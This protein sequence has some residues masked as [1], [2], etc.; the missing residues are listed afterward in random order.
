MHRNSSTMIDDVLEELT[1]KED[2]LKENSLGV[3]VKAKL[4]DIASAKSFIEGNRGNITKVRLYSDAEIMKKGGKELLTLVLYSVR[5]FYG[6]IYRALALPLLGDIMI[7]AFM[8]NHNV[9]IDTYNQLLIQDPSTRDFVSELNK[10]LGN[11][12]EVEAQ[13]AEEGYKKIIPFKTKVPNKSAT[14]LRLANP[15]DWIKYNTRK[16]EV[17]SNN[18]DETLWSVAEREARVYGM[19]N[20]PYG[21][22]GYLSNCIMYFLNNS[23]LLNYGSDAT[24]SEKVIKDIAW[25]GA[26][27]GEALYIAFQKVGVNT[28]N[29]GMQF[30]P[31]LYYMRLMGAEGLR[32][33]NDLHGIDNSKWK[34]V[35][36]SYKN[37]HW[38]ITPNKE[39]GFDVTHKN[40]FSNKTTFIGNYA[41]VANAQSEISGTYGKLPE[42]LINAL[43]P[44]KRQ[45]FVFD[46]KPKSPG[47]IE[48]QYDLNTRERFN[49]QMR[50]LV[51][52]ITVPL[53]LSLMYDIDYD[54]ETG[55]PILVRNDEFK[56]RV[57][58]NMVNSFEKSKLV[59]KGL[60]P[61]S[62]Q[63]KTGKVWRTPLDLRGT[64]LEPMFY[65]LYAADDMQYSNF[66]EA[67]GVLSPNN[68]FGY[69]TTIAKLVHASL[70]LAGNDV[71]FKDFSD[72]YSSL[73]SLGF[74]YSNP[75]DQRQAAS[76]Y[77][78]REKLI[79]KL[80]EPFVRWAY[81]G[82]MW[83]SINMISGKDE[84]R[85]RSVAPGLQ[86]WADSFH[87][88]T[89]FG[90]IG[91]LKD[92]SI[93]AHT[94]KWLTS[95]WMQSTGIPQFMFGLN[96]KF[97][98]NFIPFVSSTGIPEK[99][100][101]N[102]YGNWSF[103]APKRNLEEENGYDTWITSHKDVFEGYTYPPLNTFINGLTVNEENR[104]LRAN[105]LKLESDLVKLYFDNNKGIAAKIEEIPS[106][107]S[108]PGYFKDNEPIKT[109]HRI[110]FNNNLRDKAYQAAIVL[111]IMK[112][113]AENKDNNSADALGTNLGTMPENK[114]PYGGDG[115]LELKYV[116]SDK[117]SFNSGDDKWVKAEPKPDTEPF[118]SMDEPLNLEVNTSKLSVDLSSIGYEQGVTINTNISTDKLKDIFRVTTINVPIKG[119]DGIIRY[120]KRTG[121]A[122]NAQN[123]LVHY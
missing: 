11:T 33:I 42:W 4:K 60:Q 83:R 88:G 106:S 73:A 30:F 117:S 112:L 79:K 86:Q 38:T 87:G 71:F 8:T 62:V 44:N 111:S 31:F 95:D 28:F 25:I 67:G 120:E 78:A 24:N 65:G 69:Y 89:V 40:T 22:T 91:D 96:G 107:F 74:A 27:I 15:A 109:K 100:Y 63:I 110:R 7:R 2:F 1:E 98:D 36:D 122:L 68:E 123:L 34:K 116:L 19:M 94:A 75:L 56:L 35:G 41:T 64:P 121:V 99:V 66:T 20:K 26:K 51:G 29:L 21:Y 118:G 90:A 84:I 50:A 108:A 81:G 97:E 119:K 10:A 39:S 17:I 16:Q 102:V 54:K 113:M 92:A 72:T 57:N 103:L 9:V 45:T 3:G 23:S 49:V 18:T 80:R 32:K 5:L 46:P 61:R 114:N 76:S 59:E 53:L 55:R 104:Q 85:Y 14:G 105:I 115:V 58:G 52:T 70:Q 101:P 47:K 43:D 82:N 93:Q 77:S 12:A 13:M 48:S 37:G 6:M